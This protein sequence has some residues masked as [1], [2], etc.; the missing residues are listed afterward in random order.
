MYNHGVGE[1]SW[2]SLGQQG[3]PTGPSQR[4]SVVN[5]H[6]KDWCWSWNFG[7]PMWRTDSLE[8][9][10]MLGKSEGGRRRGWQRMRWL[11]GIPDSM[12]M[13]LSKLR[14]L[15]MD[16]QAWRA[17]VHVD[18]KS[19]TWLSNWNELCVYKYI[20]IFFFF[21]VFSIIGYYKILC[22]SY[23]TDLWSVIILGFC[24]SKN[25]AILPCNRKSLTCNPP[26]HRLYDVYTASPSILTSLDTWVVTVILLLTF[27]GKKSQAGLPKHSEWLECGCL[28]KPVAETV[29]NLPAVQ[30]MWVRCLG[31]E[32]PPEDGTAT[33]SSVLAWRIHGQRS[34]VGYSPW[35]PRESDTTEH[36]TLSNFIDD[37]KL[38]SQTGDPVLVRAPSPPS[39]DC[40]TSQ[41]LGQWKT[42]SFL[43][44]RVV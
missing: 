36:L 20:Y 15:V 34:L 8:K 10:L 44:R 41:H 11:D 33:H 13:S 4:K 16:G 7:H 37:G 27:A 5:I 1:D 18:G 9:T 22:G 3:D 31:W 40:C 38:I 29:E 14:E 43:V 21:W 25:G 35:G 19:Q 26:Q 24:F 39:L 42:F 12:D 6:G 23:T 28:F 2:E 30:D 17:A 32:D